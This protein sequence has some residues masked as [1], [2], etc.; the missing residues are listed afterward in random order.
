MRSAGR[1][2]PPRR[3]RLTAEQRRESIL[4]AAT[5]LFATAGYRAVK[6]SDVAA[7]VGV[8]EPVVFQN[9]GSK[10]ALYAAV[11]DRVTEQFR[12]AL[13][14]L[15]GRHGSALNLLAHLLTL[16]SGEVPHRKPDDGHPHEHAGRSRGMLLADA[17]SLVAAPVLADPALAGPAV[18][19]A[20]AIA[21]HIA[22]LLRRGQADGDVRP[23]IDPDATAW[24]LLSILS[25]RA[26][27]NAAMP[28]AGHLEAAVASL[29][30]D[31]LA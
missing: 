4:A 7:R 25:A 26:F 21:D 31:L 22:G 24:L 14:S 2:D 1:A 16:A 29:A 20:R 3:T 9:F 15:I 12:D 28:D 6:V 27:R 10:A 19:A 11:L 17:A 13:P 5:D 8:S 30:L 18:R 23:G